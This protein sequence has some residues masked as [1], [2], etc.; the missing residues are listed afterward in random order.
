MVLAL[1]IAAVCALWASGEPITLGNLAVGQAN[2]YVRAARD[3]GT[4]PFV[5][6]GDTLTVV[7]AE[8]V[9][10]GY[11]VVET[12]TGGDTASVYILSVQGSTLEV[13]TLEAGLREVHLELLSMLAAADTLDLLAHWDSAWQA[14]AYDSIYAREFDFGED[15]WWAIRNAIPPPGPYLAGYVDSFPYLPGITGRTHIFLDR[16]GTPIDL[17]AHG[18]AYNAEAGLMMAWLWGELGDVSYELVRGGNAAAATRAR[19]CGVT[20]SGPLP[21]LVVDLRGRVLGRST[22]HERLDGCN[23]VLAVGL[24][25]MRICPK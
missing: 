19:R 1:S 8:A 11:R 21:T 22:S 6:A 25:G 10:Q 20:G 13:T 17:P 12:L 24:T 7:L 9:G 5:Y 2:R 3:R 15:F 23:V 4:D 16:S 18:L 14:N